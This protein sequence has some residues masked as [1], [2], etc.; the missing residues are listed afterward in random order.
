MILIGPWPPRR[1]PGKLQSVET[2]EQSRHAT[3]DDQR[4]MKRAVGRF[5]LDKRFGVVG[6]DQRQFDL[7]QMSLRQPRGGVAQRD[8]LQ[9]GAHLGDLS[10]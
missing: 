2:G 8:H 7:R 5:E 4:M 1:M 6:L 10:H 3:G 9:R